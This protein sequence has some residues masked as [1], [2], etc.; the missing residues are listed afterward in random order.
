MQGHPPS[1]V[2]GSKGAGRLAPD[3][4]RLLPLYKR[5]EDIMP[6]ESHPTLMHLVGVRAADRKAPFPGEGYATLTPLCLQLLKQEAL[7]HSG[8][9]ER[10]LVDRFLS[11]YLTSNCIRDR[12]GVGEVGEGKGK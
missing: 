9:V 11:T 1:T 8:S 7:W 5:A 3:D 6:P 4:M 12:K 10:H 2:T